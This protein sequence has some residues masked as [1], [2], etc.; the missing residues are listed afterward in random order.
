MLGLPMYTWCVCVC[1]LYVSNSAR[2]ANEAQIT[3]YNIICGRKCSYLQITTFFGFLCCH[4]FSVALSEAYRA[5]DV[6]SIQLNFRV[7]CTLLSPN[8]L[9][10][11]PIKIIPFTKLDE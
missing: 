5:P 8:I 10:V 7:L 3:H 6:E 4:K 2:S 11:T 1:V 9:L